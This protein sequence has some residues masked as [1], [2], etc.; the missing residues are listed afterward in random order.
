MK[1][2]TATPVKAYLKDQD[3]TELEATI[4]PVRFMTDS[5]YP[6]IIVDID[7]IFEEFDIAV[8]ISVD[9]L[10]PPI[11]EAARLWYEDNDKSEPDYLSAD[12]PDDYDFIEVTTEYVPTPLDPF[13]GWCCSD[14]QYA[15]ACSCDECQDFVAAHD[16]SG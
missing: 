7:T 12:A 4:R 15:R 14:L 1:R 16:C 3:F 13:E 6:G 11:E 2:I 10:L 8:E 5:P 9:D